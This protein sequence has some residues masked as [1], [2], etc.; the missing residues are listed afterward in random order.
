MK[1][2]VDKDTCIGCGLCPEVCAEIFE[3]EDDGKA[4]ASTDEVAENIVS[5]AKEAEEQCPVGA[6]T[7]G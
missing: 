5:S 6:I 4:V 7:V 1:A 2:H 3:M